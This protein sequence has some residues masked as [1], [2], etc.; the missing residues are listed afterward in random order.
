VSQTLAQTLVRVRILLKDPNPPAGGTVLAVTDVDAYHTLMD[1]AQIMAPDLGLGRGWVSA[2][3][4]ISDTESSDF[5]PAVGIEYE[6]ILELVRAS[7]HWPLERVSNTEMEMLSAA[8]VPVPAC[9]LRRVRGWHGRRERHTQGRDFISPPRRPAYWVEH[10]RI[11]DEW[12]FHMFR[13]RDGR[14]I[15]LRAGHKMPKDVNSNGA[16]E[17]EELLRRPWLRSGEDWYISYAGDGADDMREL[18]RAGLAALD[19]DFGAVD[20]ARLEDGSV[21]VLEVNTRPGLDEGGETVDRY[22]REIRRRCRA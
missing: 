19:L 17:T 8:G 9:S 21:R 14:V 22:V 4:A 7:D 12:R 16:L 18:A 15:S 20:L 6:T 5:S 11:A 1:L 3:I 13:R 10:L 2:W